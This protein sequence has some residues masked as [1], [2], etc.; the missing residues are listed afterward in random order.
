MYTFINLVKIM[1]IKDE[2]EFMSFFF[3][4]LLTIMWFVFAAGI[5]N[6]VNKYWRYCQA[7]APNP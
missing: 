4:H 3:S 7:L 2:S 6:K 1:K 5:N